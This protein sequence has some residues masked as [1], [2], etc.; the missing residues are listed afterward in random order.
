MNDTEL[1]R[2]LEEKFK[3]DQSESSMDEWKALVCNET[4]GRCT[5]DSIKTQTTNDLYNT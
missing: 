4:E 3:L 2:V 1:S 5:E